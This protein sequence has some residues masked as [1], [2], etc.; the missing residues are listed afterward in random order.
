MASKNKNIM[1]EIHR[2]HKANGGEPRTT[3]ELRE[4]YEASWRPTKARI[5]AHFSNR[6]LGGRIRV[7]GRWVMKGKEQTQN[8]LGLGGSVARWALKEG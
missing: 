7:D 6:A 4:L 2:L 1:D 3:A 5:G 8:T